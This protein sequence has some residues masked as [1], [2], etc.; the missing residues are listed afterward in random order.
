M[1]LLLATR[2][3]VYVAWLLF[4]AAD[5]SFALT[6]QAAE[7]GYRVLYRAPAGL[8][9]CAPVPPS[10]SNGPAPAWE[11]GR[12]AT[13]VKS[14]TSP[15]PAPKAISP[16][17]A[18]AR[19]GGP[20]Q[21][22]MG[23]FKSV[24]MSNMVN[25]FTGN[26]SYNIPLLDVGGYPVNLYYDG[27]VGLEQDA[28]WVGLG[29]NINPGSIS[30]NMRGI[31][32]DFDGTDTLVQTT[33]L[34]PD[35][36]FGVRTSADLEGTGVK[37]L[38]PSLDLSVGVSWNNYLGMALDLGV[39]GGVGFSV[40]DKVLSEKA[41]LSLGASLGGDLSSRSG[42]T[43]SPSVSLTASYFSNDRL[44]TLGP[45]LAT[46]Y[47][48]REGIKSLQIS[49]QASANLHSAQNGAWPWSE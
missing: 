28:S 7:G 8:Y 9:T 48:S 24:N 3:R 33:N 1:I 43:L 32:D 36:T 12:P 40:A 4:I 2:Y 10:K 22:E 39:K 41:S 17:P 45:S 29:W 34:K 20:N 25:L 13:A 38:P 30:R 23:S 6:A 47:N 46:S 44:F 31:P 18:H 14:G 16:S 42:L 49:E 27:E 21:P 19:V 15:R 37:V 11:P 26:F 5:V 35:V